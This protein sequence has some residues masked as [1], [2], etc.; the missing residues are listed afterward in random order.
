MRESSWVE[1]MELEYKSKDTYGS[2]VQQRG[3]SS[4]ETHRRSTM[5]T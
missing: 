3:Q 2:K 4:N 5:I 1:M